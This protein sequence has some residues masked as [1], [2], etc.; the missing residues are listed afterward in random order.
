LRGTRLSLFN[1]GFPR[2]FGRLP[3]N[4]FGSGSA[5]T[6]SSLRGGLYERALSFAYKRQP[7]VALIPIDTHQ[8]AQVDLIGGQ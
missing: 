6:D 3:V 7:V 4:R 8:V 5:S 1:R 2:G